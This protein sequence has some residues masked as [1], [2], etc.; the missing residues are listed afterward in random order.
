MFTILNE[1]LRRSLATTAAV[2]VIAISG[3][4]FEFGHVGALP[5]GS[6]EVGELQPVGLEQ[7]A[8]VTLPGIVVTA[9]RLPAGAPPQDLP[10]ATVRLASR[11]TDG[12]D[13][14][15]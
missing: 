6:V 8:A 5:A 2:C 15:G 7:L 1:T 11:D 9:A 12:R 13:A 10:A 4:G 3:L 14:A